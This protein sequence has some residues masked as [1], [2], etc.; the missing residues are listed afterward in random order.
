M[1]VFLKIK[2]DSNT[3]VSPPKAPAKILGGGLFAY[4]ISSKNTQKNSL[5]TASFGRCIKAY[6]VVFCKQKL[7]LLSLTHPLRHKSFVIQNRSSF[8]VNYLFPSCNAKT[9]FNKSLVRS[10][11][12]V[13]IFC[14]STATLTNTPSMALFV[15]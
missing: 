6:F 14:S 8:D 2:N 4:S 13:L 12:S 11:K 1:S 3:G 7:S 15:T 10:L 5:D 9:F